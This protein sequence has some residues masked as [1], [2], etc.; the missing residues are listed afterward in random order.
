MNSYRPQ[1]TSVDAA[2]IA[3]MT[4]QPGGRTAIELTD[5]TNKPYRD[6]VDAIA[7]LAAAGIVTRSLERLG[8]WT[9]ADRPP[10][11]AA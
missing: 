3:A 5:S 7:R 6:V 1:H 2:I 9:L 8:S 4:D 10:G 11:E